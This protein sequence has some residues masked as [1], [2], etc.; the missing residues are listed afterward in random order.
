MAETHMDIQN[1]LEAAA[2]CRLVYLTMLSVQYL[3]QSEQKGL[4][5][6]RR[7]VLGQKAVPF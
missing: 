2:F 4:R 7:C 1:V 6:S 3:V 5:G